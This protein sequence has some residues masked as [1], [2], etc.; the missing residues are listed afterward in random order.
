MLVTWATT[1]LGSTSVDLCGGGVVFLSGKK[2]LEP[3]EE[4]TFICHLDGGL[5]AL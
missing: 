5:V 1:L 3:S 4:T 2:D